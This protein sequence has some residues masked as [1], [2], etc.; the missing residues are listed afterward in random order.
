MLAVQH[1]FQLHTP[2]LGKFQITH[3][4]TQMGSKLTKMKYYH[5]CKSAPSSSLQ[6]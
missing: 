2:R 6:K 3:F 1:L 5:V 4:W